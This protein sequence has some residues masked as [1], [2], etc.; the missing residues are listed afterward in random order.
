MIF[1]YS[2]RQTRVRL[3]QEALLNA[4]DPREHNPPAYEEAIRMPKPIF[5]S[6]DEL[7]TRRSRRKR[8]AQKNE[9]GEGGQEEVTETTFRTHRYRSEEVSLP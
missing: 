8:R 1:I 7:S 6:L 4:P 9:D 5:A 3:Q 2:A